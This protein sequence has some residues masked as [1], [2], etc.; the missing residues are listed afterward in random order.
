MKIL[1]TVLAIGLSLVVADGV[2]FSSEYERHE[3][4]GYEHSER[5]GS[6]IYGT[7]EKVPNGLIGTW[8]I[9]GKEILV[10]KDTFI[11]EEYGRAEVGAYVEVYGRYSD[12]TFTAYKIEV[13]RARR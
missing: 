6:K 7:I 2:V 13:K 12:K 4:K 3:G 10:T 11:K 9:N 1:S 8:V 5:Y